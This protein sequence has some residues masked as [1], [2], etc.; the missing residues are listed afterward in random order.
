VRFRR[1]W[2]ETS[3]CSTSSSQNGFWSTGQVLPR[4]T[5]WAWHFV[6]SVCTQGSLTA[7]LYTTPHKTQALCAM[8]G[9]WNS[10]GLQSR[11]S[12]NSATLKDAISSWALSP[13]PSMAGV[14]CCEIK[15]IRSDD[16]RISL[17]KFS[18][19]HFK[20]MF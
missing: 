1:Y 6:H 14:E 4:S 19:V 20:I 18:R 10:M 8:M 15:N 3:S 7:F 5:H 17:N 2:T 13:I 16:H 9:S 12:E 11:T